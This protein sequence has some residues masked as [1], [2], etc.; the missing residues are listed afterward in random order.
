MKVSDEQIRAV[1]AELRGQGANV[2]GA[3]VRRELDARFGA[4]GGV[5][6]IYRV[7]REAPAAAPAEVARLQE[8]LAKARKRAELAEQREDAHQL[9][10]AKEVDGLRQRVKELEHAQAE[11]MRWQDAYQ[12]MAIELRA[13]EM[14]MARLERERV[15]EAPGL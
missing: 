8:E 15:G 5:T 3:R 6:H 12:R 4:R 9:M 10:W 1:A 14:R 13:A 11:A 2:T 7:L